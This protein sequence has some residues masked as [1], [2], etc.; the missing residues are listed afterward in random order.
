[1]FFVAVFFA[2][3][4]FVDVGFNSNFLDSNDRWNCLERCRLEPYIF[5]L[6]KNIS[7]GL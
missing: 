3:I 1:M 7:A 6:Y 5:C 4:M 2:M